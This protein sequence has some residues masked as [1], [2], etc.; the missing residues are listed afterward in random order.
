[1]ILLDRYLITTFVKAWL[2]LFVSLVSL[3]VIIDAFSHFEE[4]LQAS[5]FM[6]KTITETLS[7]YYSYQ[8]VLI[9]DRLCGVILL[10]ASTFTI[11]WMQRQNEMVALLSAGVPTQRIIRPIYLG[12]LFFLALQ[13]INRELIMP[14]LSDQLEHSAAD[15]TGQK[16]KSITG[17]F[18][19]TGVLLEGTRAI[20]AEQLVR[21]MSCTVPTQLGGTMYHIF[22][23][24]ARFIPE[25]TTLPDGSRQNSPGWLLY[26]TTPT[27]VPAGG[28]GGVM[29]PLSTGQTFVKIEQMDFRRITRNKM[30]FQFASLGEIVSE[31]ESSGAQQLPALAT[32][33]HQRLAAPLV[34]LVSITLGMGII[35]R[36]SSRNIFLNAGL[37][38]AAAACVFMTTMV[39]KYLGEREIISTALAGWMPIFIFG[40]LAYTLRDGMQS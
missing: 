5:R 3:Y 33:L 37:C 25:G 35:L 8:L 40:P 4:L 38:L 34:T 16:A 14:L 20:P 31:M 17:G 9:F 23:K 26:N 22:A 7:I 15:P 36:E 12:C 10:L 32:Q 13:T 21:N 11:A 19:K 30:W 2:A 24:E 27:E 6:Q 29:L 39:G 1:M 18:D 28:L